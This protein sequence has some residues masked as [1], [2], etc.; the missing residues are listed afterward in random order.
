MGAGQREPSHVVIEIRRA[1][2]RCRMTLR[3]FIRKA[4]RNVVGVIRRSVIRF[5]TGDTR[6]RSSCESC[7]MTTV[8]AH[9]CMGASE[10]KVRN[11][12][13]KVGRC[14]GNRRVTRRAGC[15]ET[16]SRMIGIGRVRVIGFVAGITIGRC[17]GV[18][19]RVA[20]GARH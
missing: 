10:R 8:A 15:R 6:G 7:G 14:P 3:A 13:V 5:M 4:R 1:P 17:S 12:M 11:V 2:S 20:V 9:T 16:G 18:T 19:R